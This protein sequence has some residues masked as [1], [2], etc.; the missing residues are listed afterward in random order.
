MELSRIKFIT[1]QNLFQSHPI[2][3]K[4]HEISITEQDLKIVF[5]NDI[6]IFQIQSTQHTDAHICAVV[7]VLQCSTCRKLKH[8]TKDQRRA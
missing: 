4:P 5:T 1:S 8:S 3:S 2:H 6:H 7:L